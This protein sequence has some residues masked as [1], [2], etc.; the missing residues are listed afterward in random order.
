L[1][2]LGDAK[3]FGSGQLDFEGLVLDDFEGR[4][5]V[6]ELKLEGHEDQTV[7]DEEENELE[8][9]V[10]EHHL[11]VDEANKNGFFEGKDPGLCFEV[12]RVEVEDS[13]GLVF[14]DVGHQNL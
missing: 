10:A 12:A 7:V 4:L 3:G 6:S 14:E 8:K 9:R 2:F 1:D 5:G 13:G 11:V